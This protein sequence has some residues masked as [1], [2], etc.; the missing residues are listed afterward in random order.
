MKMVMKRKKLNS[1]KKCANER[2]IATIEA[3]LLLSIFV[4][5]MTYCVGTFGVIHTGILN[6][7][8]ARAYTFETIRNRANVIYFRDTGDSPAHTAKY[9]VRVHGITTEKADMRDDKWIVTERTMSQGREVA[10]IEASRPQEKMNEL[11]DK[12]RET[13]AVN[14]VWIKTVYGICLNF[15][16]GGK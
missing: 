7:I 2:G 12:K 3:A 14:P 1:R 4:V 9:G 10:N 13:G 8:S 16:C 5:F 11:F 15:Q 6:S